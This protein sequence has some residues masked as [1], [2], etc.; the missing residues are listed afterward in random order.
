MGSAEEDEDES[1]TADSSETEDE[2]STKK[3][4]KSS[5]RKKDTTEEEQPSEE[6]PSEEKPSKKSRK[7]N[8]E[9]DETAKGS[10]R[11]GSKASA[12]PAGAGRPKHGL[13]KSA[14]GG[15]NNNNGG[16]S[17]N[18]LRGDSN[19]PT[20]NGGAGSNT[21]A[22]GGGAR[23]SSITTD[24]EDGGDKGLLIELSLERQEEMTKLAKRQR[25]RIVEHQKEKHQL[26]VNNHRES[27]E[28]KE[29]VNDIE[30]LD[31][32]IERLNKSK[33]LLDDDMVT[34]L[35]GI[36]KQIKKEQQNKDKIVE[37]WKWTDGLLQAK[38]TQ[39]SVRC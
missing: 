6:K 28:Y 13:N 24:N 35:S 26:D 34:A 11:G 4:K 7:H 9:N 30:Q 20:T 33:T 2:V 27:N 15:S 36:D 29:Q 12:Q 19:T 5:K 10:R 16:G 14:S 38:H 25:L 3:K 39:H 17:R 37:S 8:K 18:A 23:N 32:R 22:T 21:S 1:L 31:S